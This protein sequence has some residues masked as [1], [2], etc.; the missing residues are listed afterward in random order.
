IAPPLPRLRFPSKRDVVISIPPKLVAIPPPLFD[1][2]LFRN[3][4]LVKR[5]L[6]LERYAPPPS[7]AWLPSNRQL[8]TSVESE[9]IY[10]PPPL[11][12]L[13]LFSKTQFSNWV[14]APQS[15]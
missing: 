14:F 15:C 8:L 11:S 10:N 13:S 6:S 3:T 2:S 7:T 4:E 5:L 1:A 12:S 9:R